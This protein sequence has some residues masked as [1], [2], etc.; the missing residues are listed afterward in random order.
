[1]NRELQREPTFV[2]HFREWFLHLKEKNSSFEKKK[3][4]GKKKEEKKPKRYK[5]L[6]IH[7]HVSKYAQ[8]IKEKTAKIRIK[9]YFLASRATSKFHS[10][11]LFSRK[12]RELEVCFEPYVIL[13]CNRHCFVLTVE[14][15]LGM[16]ISSLHGSAGDLQ[17]LWHHLWLVF[18]LD[19]YAYYP[20]PPKI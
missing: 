14:K 20:H 13:L 18:P 6:I 4:R 7:F 2:L 12:L 15:N 8:R 19:F 17:P 1:M 11:F 16:R 3:K 9:H 5:L 10:M